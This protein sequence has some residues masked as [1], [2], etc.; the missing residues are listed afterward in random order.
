MLGRP[1][2]F[3]FAPS[4]PSHTTLRMSTPHATATRELL[5]HPRPLF[6]LFFAELWERFSYYGMRALLTFFM[7]APVAK[8]G[9]GLPAAKAALIYGTYTM[10]VYMLSIPGG[11][12]ADNLLGSRMAVLVG[13]QATDR[14]ARRLRACGVEAI[15]ISTGRLCHLEAAR[16]AEAIDQLPLAALDLLVIDYIQLLAGSGKRSDSRVQ[17]VTEIGR[18]SCRER[19]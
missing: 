14:D 2:D 6:T 8:G 13:D 17:E 4:P 19:V 16:V 15:A 18:A 5:G 11:T 10:S 3:R 7:V 1:G 9:L 12:I